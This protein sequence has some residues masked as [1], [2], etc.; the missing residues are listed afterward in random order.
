MRRPGLVAVLVAS[1]ILATATT[2]L[3]SGAGASAQPGKRPY[4]ID[5]RRILA[6]SRVVGSPDPLPP[7]RVRK[8]FPNLRIDYPIAVCHQPGSDR[9]LIIT[10]KVPYGPTTLQRLVDDHDTG[11]VEMLLK[12][13]ATAYT[14]LFHPDFANNGYLYVSSNGP[15]KGKGPKKTQIHRY[16]MER[17]PPYHLDPQSEK[18]IIEWE[19]DGHNG[20]G[21]A[22]G[23]DGLFYV[24]SGDG[25]SDSDRL[26]VGQDMSSLLAKVLRI[27]VDNHDPGKGYAV[28][29]D[30]P[31]LGT[32][33]A[34]PEIWAYG[35]RNPWRLTVDRQT[36][37]LWLGQNGQDLWEQA[38]LVKK[39]ENYGSSVTEGS[40]PFYPNRK[41]GPTPIV[42]PTIEHH[43][44]E[45]RSLTGGIVYYGDKHPELRGAYIYGD[46]STGKIWALRHDGERVLWHKELADSRLQI[47]GFG[48][49]SKGEMLIA[50]HRGDG[51]G[52]FYTL[53]PTPRNAKPADFPGTLT[54]TGLFT[55]VKGHVVHP[56]LI[57]YSVIAPLW[58]DNAFKERWI[59]LPGADT[60]IDFTNHRGWNSPDGAVIVKSFGLEFKEGDA[61]SRKWIETRLL[62][63]ERGEWFGSSYAW[64]DEQ[65]EAFLVEG[66]GR[67]RDY[68]IQT[69]AGPRQ[70]VWHYPSRTECMVCHSRAANWVL[71]L[72]TLQM[73]KDH[74]YGGIIDNQLRTLAH[75]GVLKANWTKEVQTVLREDANR[76]GL[77]DKE[78]DAYIKEHTPPGDPVE[79]FI[80][81]MSS[82]KGRR[83]VDPYDAK[84][85]IALRARSYLH[86]NC[87]QCHVEA[88]GGNAMIDL[89]FTT[90]L[91][92]MKLID[93]RPQHDSFALKDAKLI[94]P[95]RP[96]TSVLL[97]RAGCRGPGQ[98]PPL[99]TS[100]VDE[101]A[102]EMLREW[103]RGMKAE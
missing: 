72:Q 92:K 47:T 69:P 49:D 23:N 53:E 12:H 74:D 4:G 42:K 60:R 33:G 93:V 61:G 80:A 38:Y 39:G 43:H 57:P 27:D 19:S 91:D 55:S 79:A 89:E 95:G 85:D 70:Q 20:G 51:Q 77:K 1:A 30:N 56:A 29:K 84:Q 5:Q 76:L 81:M 14:I 36:G 99:A 65:T 59:A 96:E 75:I 32:K 102:V 63:R 34:R 68:L 90:K 52:N 15:E 101:P 88:G 37:H 64:N 83:L 86:S 78:R 87:A 10:Q 73:N 8:V 50:D 26:V 18:L 48:T 44:S 54:E 103:V 66:K 11:D 58:G 82:E 46:Y 40:H 71:G 67:D 31:F 25:T 45:F 3:W 94:A 21:M 28:P 6:T 35:V 98:M 17:Q 2:C 41:L 24:T 97:Y 100:L 16:I 9:L 22:F 62:T 7:Y 13:N